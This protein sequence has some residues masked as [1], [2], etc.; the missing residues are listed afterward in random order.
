MP[1]RKNRPGKMKKVAN[2]A[3]AAV[4]KALHIPPFVNEAKRYSDADLQRMKELY[5]ESCY[6]F[7][8]PPRLLFSWSR[9]FQSVVSQAGTYLCT[10]QF[11][12]GHCAIYKTEGGCV[13]KG[14][15]DLVLGERTIYWDYGRTKE[16]DSD[17]KKI[18]HLINEVVLS[19]DPNDPVDSML[20]KAAEIADCPV[21][22]LKAAIEK[23]SNGGAF[24]GNSLSS[25]FNWNP[26]DKPPED[27]E[28]IRWCRVYISGED[29]EKVDQSLADKRLGYELLEK[30]EEKGREWKKK[31]GGGYISLPMCCNPRRD[32]DGKLFF[33]I[34]TGRTDN[35]TGW[36]TQDEIE[37]YL[38]TDGRI[39]ETR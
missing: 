14:K 15:G 8:R 25:F 23:S 9:L 28:Y 24:G 29:P 7:H 33:W 1:A 38:K 36:K 18:I 6:A 27:E 26:F 21:G 16:N 17:L 13:I 10:G 4:K 34:N 22:S 12:S 2:A 11:H 30:M 19:W 39:I 3:V 5:R 31:N 37:A 35:L 20:N 32:P